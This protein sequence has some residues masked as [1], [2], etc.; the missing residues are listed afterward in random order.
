MWTLIRLEQSDLSLLCLPIPNCLTTQV[1][2]GNDQVC[3]VC[4]FLLAFVLI[5]WCTENQSVL[6]C[7]PFCQCTNEESVEMLWFFITSWPF[8]HHPHQLITLI[9]CESIPCRSC[10][11]ILWTEGSFAVRCMYRMGKGK[12]SQSYEIW[13]VFLVVFSN[14]LPERCHRTSG[15]LLDL[16]HLFQVQP[17]SLKEIILSKLLLLKL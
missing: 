2:Y 7:S 17:L 1:Y 11:L 16:H 10:D 8:Y 13:I 14:E 9:R 4:Q 6:N 15:I 3:T 12:G 5:L